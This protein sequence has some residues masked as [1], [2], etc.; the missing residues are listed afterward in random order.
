MVHAS[1]PRSSLSDRS[2]L[3]AEQSFQDI[4]EF[5]DVVGHRIVYCIAEQPNEIT[6]P[7]SP[8]KGEIEGHFDYHVF[9]AGYKGDA[10]FPADTRGRLP[11]WRRGSPPGGSA[12]SHLLEIS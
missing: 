11:S 8:V 1:F 9:L 6:I 10:C 7:Q 4:A 2:T 12:D 5:R 3:D